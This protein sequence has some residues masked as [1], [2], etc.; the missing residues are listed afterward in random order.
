[1]EFLSKII[2][3]IYIIYSILCMRTT[4][5]ITMEFFFQENIFKIQYV[6]NQSR[7]F[8][9]VFSCYNFKIE[10]LMYLMSLSKIQ[11]KSR[12]SLSIIKVKST[13]YR[14]ENSLEN[15]QHN[16]SSQAFVSSEFRTFDYNGHYNGTARRQGKK[17][18]R[19]I[20]AAESASV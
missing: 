19:V 10:Q 12:S 7:I 2:Q 20:H 8:N 15:K 13:A 14:N 17:W 5:E 18:P 6:F 1:M 9:S 11:G 4:G 3:P 16:T